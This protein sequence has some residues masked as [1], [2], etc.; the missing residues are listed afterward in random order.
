M[1][2]GPLKIGSV[3]DRYEVRTLLGRGGMAWV[4]SAYQPWLQREVAIKVTRCAD[5][6]EAE[7]ARREAQLLSQLRH[8]GIVAVFDAG[9]SSDSNLLFIVMELLHGCSLRDLLGSGQALTVTETLELG[10]QLCEAAEAAH[11]QGTIHRDLKPE[12]IFIQEDN[13]AKILD[14][15]VAR[16]AA[17]P[18]TQRIL[19][20]TPLYLA[21]EYLG[22]EGI[23]HR[24][25]IYA[26]GM[27]LYECL[28]GEHPFLKG[29][30]E[31]DEIAIARL[32][33]HEMPP[34]LHEFTHISKPLALI[35]QRALAKAP[36]DRWQTMGEFGEALRSQQAEALQLVVLPE[37]PGT[38]KGHA[39]SVPQLS[40]LMRRRG[41]PLAIAIACGGMLVAAALSQFAGYQAAPLDHS[42]GGEAPA[43]S[44]AAALELASPPHPMHGPLGK[45]GPVPAPSHDGALAQLATP[46]V[47]GDVG[48]ALH[49]SAAEPQ[50]REPTG[51]ASEPA[52]V[53]EGRTGMAVRAAPWKKER[54]ASTRRQ[55]GSDL[56]VH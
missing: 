23:D 10:V 30:R 4:Y 40:K 25:D 32:Q 35:I 39:I 18:S 34:P 46:V 1:E 2:E 37:A 43:T 36:G 17:S 22:G 3:F 28:A 51:R 29:G 7:C 45:D 44:A 55:Y 24:A 13:R 5:P 53:E 16:L 6:E 50:Q 47:A 27:T 20:G 41:P 42:L 21:P 11:R 31:L 19:R 9:V 14:F 54:A 8:P 12:N 38:L 33:L 56:W 48:G 52:G 26:L 15:G 49:G